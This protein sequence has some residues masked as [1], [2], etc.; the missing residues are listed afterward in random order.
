M[1]REEPKVAVNRAQK[2]TM[3]RFLYEDKEKLLELY[4]ALNDSDYTDADQLEI[5][6]LESAI[7]MSMKND[8]AFVIDHRLYLYEH[9]STYNPNMPL[10]DLFYVSNE[11]QKLIGDK[12]SLYA[13]K[14]VKIPA[15][16]FV[17]FYNGT[18]KRPEREWLRLSD[19][20][21]VSEENPMLELQVLVLN[22]NEGNNRELKE[23][24]RCLAE[25]MLYADRIRK[26]AEQYDT[27]QEAV[28][29][30]IEDCIAEGILAD[31]LTKHRA[32]AM[33]VSIFEYDEEKELRLYGEAERE[34]GF[35]RGIEQ[36]IE[37]T[38]Y[39]LICKKIEKNIP[40]EQ[41]ARE[42]EM[43]L[44]ELC[45]YYEKAKREVIEEI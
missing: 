5:V 26:Y 36:G 6:T 40:I 14:K 2:D 21:E 22:I 18:R 31:F 38:L 39:K 43:E 28:E 34:V 20:Y 9:Q 12:K 7:Y 33:T 11:Y 13:S 25:Y 45:P 35:E 15:P 10:R 19:L 4:N 42:L 23:K 30:A 3:F 37:Q 29:R 44:E 32:E 17:V 24:C 16:R 27:L 1:N 8:V 41:I